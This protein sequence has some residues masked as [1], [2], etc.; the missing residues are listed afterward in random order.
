MAAV[1]GLARC[2]MAG[3]DVERARELI[4]MVPEDKASDPAI[5]GV[6]AA[7]DLA[8]KA[9]EGGDLGALMAHVT[10]APRDHAK[11]LELAQALAAH[12]DF[13]AAIGHLLEIVAAERDWNEGAARA[14]ILKVFEAAG[15]TSAAT[16]DGRRRLA[17]LLFS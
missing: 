3:G 9:N 4:G 8:A 13:E 15:P 5:Q 11:R 12:G 6:R 16:Q 14:E 2:Y 7:L 1:A 10:G 17:A